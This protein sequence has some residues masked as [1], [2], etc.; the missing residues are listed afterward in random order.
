MSF[1]VLV[2]PED[3]TNNGYILK[4]LVQAI[5]DDAGRPQARVTYCPI[6]G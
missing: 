6:R 1:K 4:P 5:L 3:P 2:I